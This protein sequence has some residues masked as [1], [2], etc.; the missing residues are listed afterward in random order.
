MSAEETSQLEA[1]YTYDPTEPA[2]DTVRDG[3]GHGE[4]YEYDFNPART[5]GDWVPEEQLRPACAAA[6]AVSDGTCEVGGACDAPVSDARA[7]CIASLDDAKVEMRIAVSCRL[8]RIQCM[9]YDPP[10]WRSRATSTAGRP[11]AKRT[12]L[13]KTECQG[14]YVSEG[15]GAVCQSCDDSCEAGAEAFCLELQADGRYTGH[16]TDRALT[17]STNCCARWG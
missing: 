4:R 13:L 5:S 7:A 17:T 14:L 12:R 16:L 6:C 9:P 2:L 1:T 11:A 15:V 3:A 8:R 10:M